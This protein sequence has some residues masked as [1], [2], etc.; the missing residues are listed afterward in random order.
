MMIA[1]GVLFGVVA[2]LGWGLADFLAKKLVDRVGGLNALLFEQLVAIVFLAPF[3]LLLGEL[4]GIGILPL[5]VAAAA[6]WTYPYLAFYKGFERGMVSV[7]S[8]IGSTWGAGGAVLAAIALGESLSLP[9]WA[10][11][12]IIAVGIF[13][14]STSWKELR[15]LSY[16]KLS[17]VEWAIA[18]LVG[19]S[20]AAV[21]MKPLVL[22]AGPFMAIWLVKI[23][24]VPMALS[25]LPFSNYRVEAPSGLWKLV[26]AI[27]VVDAIAFLGYNFGVGTGLVGVVGP[28]A[29]AFPIVTVALAWLFLKERLEKSQLVGVA[30]AVGGMALLATL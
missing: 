13:L 2:M 16:R 22:E 6:A 10:S 11:I 25:V 4:P 14:V 26:A 18:A 24:S 9:Q 17:G 23:L 28:V 5:L 15:K 21:L 27:A 29:A 30:L 1:E 20:V 12:G 8:P 19:W 3:A 7:I